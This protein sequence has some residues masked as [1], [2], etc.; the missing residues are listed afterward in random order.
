MSCAFV[1]R[2][3]RPDKRPTALI[4]K[5]LSVC[6]LALALLAWSPPGAAMT[7]H[8]AVQKVQRDTGGRVLSARTERRGDVIIH[9]IKVQTRDGVVRTVRITVR[10]DPD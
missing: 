8:E 6:F 3:R 5:F 10:R 7:L 1:C 9:H 4:K 2:P